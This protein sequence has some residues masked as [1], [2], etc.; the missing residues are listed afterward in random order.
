MSNTLE[1]KLGKFSNF[2][3]K[4]ENLALITYT[5]QME[6]KFSQRGTAENYPDQLG[7][8]A[9]EGFE[10]WQR[11][12]I[13]RIQ[14]SLPN[15]FNNLSLHFFQVSEIECQVSAYQDGGFLN[16]HEDY[17]YN[18]KRRLTY[19]YYFHTLPKAFTGGQLVI[20]NW[21]LNNDCLVN[22]KKSK[23]C[24]VVEPE[25]NSLVIFPSTAFHGI[26]PVAS[27]K[28]FLGSR[29]TIHGWVNEAA[30]LG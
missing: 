16:V 17:S 10:E 8:C 21:D 15:I 2:L 7:W 27:K 22:T 20:Y 4:D 13:E 11:V 23:S 14:K 19:V 28:G 3:T 29:F 9:L 24:Q 26:L 5:L 6:H 18:H 30:S 1:I 25:N 12:I